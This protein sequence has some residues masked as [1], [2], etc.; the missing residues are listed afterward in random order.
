MRELLQYLPP[1]AAI[2]FVLWGQR[3]ARLPARHTGEYRIVEY[4]LPY[5]LLG[6]IG[7]VLTFY[8]IARDYLDKSGAFYGYFFLLLFLLFIPLTLNAWL[9]RVRFNDHAVEVTCMWG[10]R[11][12]IPRDRVGSVCAGF[13]GWRIETKGFGRISLGP[14][15]RGYQELVDSI[16]ETGRE[17]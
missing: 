16:R 7:C 11:R 12:L 10:R 9:S 15:Q 3:A 8:L 13:M 17:S 1:L 6:P 5:K 4:P 14:Y 2:G